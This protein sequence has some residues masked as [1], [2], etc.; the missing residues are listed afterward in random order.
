MRKPLSIAVRVESPQAAPARGE[1]LEARLRRIAEPLRQLDAAEAARRFALPADALLLKTTVSL[2]PECLAHVAAAVYLDG[3]KVLMAK[4]CTAHGRSLALLEN[5]RRYYRLSSKDQWGRSYAAEPVVQIPAYSSSSACCGPSGSCGPS[6][7][8]DVWPHDSSD[9]RANKTCTVLIEITDAC[10]LACRVCYADSKGD[11]I[12]SMDSFRS[13]IDAL[14]T[15]KGSLDSVQLIGGE[16]TLHPQFWEMVAFLH[17]DLRVKK[18]YIATNGI[19]LEKPGMADR[20][21]P[22]R[23]KVLVLLQFDGAEPATNKALRQANPMRIRASL[24][25]RLDRL[26]VP[27]QLTMTLARGVSEREIAWVVRQGV[28]HKSVRLVAM[29]PVFFSGRHELAN[30]PLDRITLSDVVKGVAA[31]LAKRNRREDFLPIPCSHPNCGWVTLFA[32]RMGFVLNIAR[33]VDV[34]AVMNDVAYKT[35]LEQREIQGIIGSKRTSWMQRLATRVGRKLVRPRDVF[36]IVIKPFMDRYTYDQDRI[37]S[38]CHH[39]LDTAGRLESFCEYNA[40]HRSGD[41]WE[42]FPQFAERVELAEVAHRELAT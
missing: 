26:K 33:H 22:F 3:A 30:D 39:V 19:E 40:R 34:D 25:K 24:L 27:M 14:L 16:P 23:D 20:L 18:I 17:A 9:Q 28:R 32:R 15:L 42:N 10:N 41:S 6:T 38:C 5:D 36:G 8:S 12:L 2:C 11:R 21:L 37:S 13:R 1:T 29:L 4:L 35:V 31:G 7:G